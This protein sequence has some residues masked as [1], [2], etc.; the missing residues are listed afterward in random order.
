MLSKI[1]SLMSEF[2]L[3]KKNDK[4]YVG[5]ANQSFI[6]SLKLQLGENPDHDKL[7]HTT[8]CKNGIEYKK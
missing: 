3:S 4:I 8:N 2:E 5:G 1:W 7:L 6:K